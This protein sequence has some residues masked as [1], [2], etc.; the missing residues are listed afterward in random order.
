MIVRSRSPLVAFALLTLLAP[1]LARGATLPRGTIEYQPSLSFAYNSYSPSGGGGSGNTTNLDLNALVG[2]CVSPMW[3]VTGS[4]LVQ[5]SGTG[6]D[7]GSFSA[8]GAGAAAGLAANFAT[9]GETVPFVLLEAGFISY[10]GDGYA[11]A[12]T[13]GLFPSISGGVRWMLKNTASVNFTLT[14]QHQVNASG[15]KNLD[16]NNLL[17]GVGV[18]LFSEP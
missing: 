14:Y 11:N 15:V 4:L 10:S 13:T 12:E 3:E 1:A 6:G 8:T 7:F 16:S 17:L 9:K 18:S 2:Y 5:H